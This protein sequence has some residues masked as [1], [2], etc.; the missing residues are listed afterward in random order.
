LTISWGNSIIEKQDIF[1]LEERSY[2]GQDRKEKRKK[3]EKKKHQ[4]HINF[5]Y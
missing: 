5:R 1:Q 4:K 3:I 2:R